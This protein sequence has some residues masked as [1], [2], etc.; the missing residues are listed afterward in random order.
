[1]EKEGK[2]RKEVK[3]RIKERMNREREMTGKMEK[4][5]NEEI[6][7]KEEMKR[8]RKKGQ[9]EKKEKQENEGMRE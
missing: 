9:K 3:K 7:V 8:R 2:E 5:K 6:R 4:E 1:M